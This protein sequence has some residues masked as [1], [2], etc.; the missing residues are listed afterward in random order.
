MNELKIESTASLLE[1]KIEDE[2]Q[3]EFNTIPERE[4]L[5]RVDNDF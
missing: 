5:G 1:P 3:D 4:R 2:N